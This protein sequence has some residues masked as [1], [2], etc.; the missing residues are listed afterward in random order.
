MAK[1]D[2]KST[3]KTHDNQL[4]SFTRRVPVVKADS[5][6]KNQMAVIAKGGVCMKV[7]VERHGEDR[8]GKFWIEGRIGEMRFV[9]EQTK[10]DDR[11]QI[12]LRF[13]PYDP[14]FD[15]IQAF[16][17]DTIKILRREM[18]KAWMKTKQPPIIPY[19]KASKEIHLVVDDERK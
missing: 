13:Y 14:E 18:K 17:A 7:N 2:S 6:K 3:E 15:P 10:P 11:M 8:S 4:V 16:G 19:F 5:D 1:Q 12:G 9:G